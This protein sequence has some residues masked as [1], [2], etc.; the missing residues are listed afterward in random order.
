L[1]PQ[2]PPWRQTSGADAPGGQRCPHAHGVGS[3]AV[4]EGQYEPAGHGV[5]CVAPAAQ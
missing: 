4:A 1:P 3:H 5:G 2:N